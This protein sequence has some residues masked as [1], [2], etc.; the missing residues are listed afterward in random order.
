[1]DLLITRAKIITSDAIYSYGW[2]LCR[3]GKITALGSGDAPEFDN[4]QIIDASGKTLLPGF[5]DVHVHGAMGG[6][7]M[8]ASPDVLC[9]MAQFYARHG[10]TAFLATTW[11]D[12]HNRI[13][14]ALK[15]IRDTMQFSTG[16]AAIV[17]VH[18]EGPYLNPE[19]CGAQNKSYIRQAHPEEAL[20]YLDVGVIR[21]LSIAPEFE[22]NHWL[23]RECARRGITVSIAH[24]S[25]NY[26]ETM[27]GIEQGISHSTHTYNAMTGLHHRDPGTLGAV[28]STPHVRCELI[29][30][31]IHVHPAAMKVL[32]QAKGADHLILITDAI[33][34]AGMPEG[35]YPVDERSLYVK[36]GAARLE[37]GT[38]AGSILTMDK[39]L[40][41]FIQATG[42]TIEGVWRSTSLNA[43]RAIQLADR[44]GS[45]EIGKDADLVLID[46]QR[47]TG[48]IQ[49]HLTVV[50]GNIVY[51]PG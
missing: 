27:Y 47:D 24:S 14:A 41:N 37:D 23:I 48:N 21:L 2:L 43:A 29:A 12:S 44:K 18:L 28:M 51:R 25:A 15:T 30:D 50:A 26:V 6:D 38:L 10:V 39:A 4:V 8:D 22:E 5:I 7:S 1:M 20:A 31:N 45:L 13:S 42:E 46:H 32:W 33:R 49:I 36:D 19:K 35:E 3:D 9:N 11:T 16:G 34:A 17:G 40:G